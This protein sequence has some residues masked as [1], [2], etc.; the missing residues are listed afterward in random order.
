VTFIFYDTETTGLETAF[1]QILQFAAIVTDDAF[2]VLEEINL[3][4]RLLPYVLAS[5]G[6][7]F[8]TKVGPKT[9]QS[10]P[11][12]SYEMVTARGGHG[13][14]AACCARGCGNYRRQGRDFDNGKMDGS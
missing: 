4:C 10:A 14:G 1:D 6:A 13:T 5:P 7:M 3:R 11:L 9:I 12:S 2:N 8:V